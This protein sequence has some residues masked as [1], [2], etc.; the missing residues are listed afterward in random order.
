M[1]DAPPGRY[2]VVERGRRL[3]VI[4]TLTGQPAA[5]E[6]PAPVETRTT[7]AGGAAV[8]TTSPIYDLK[9]P[10]RIAKSDSLTN[11][12]AG[13]LAAVAIAGAVMTIAFPAL[14]IGVAFVLLQPK[15]RDAIRGWI[16]ARL[17]VFDE[18]GRD[19]AAR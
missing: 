2:K 9:G 12:A 7:R 14:W 10:R 5:R 16:T 8:F 18:M 17:D 3:V 19:Q 13:M 1:T 11:L 15:P 4:D 6:M